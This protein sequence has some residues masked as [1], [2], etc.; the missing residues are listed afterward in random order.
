MLRSLLY[1]LLLAAVLVDISPTVAFHVSSLTGHRWP[2]TSLSFCMW[3]DNP[4]RHPSPDLPFL[5]R[6]LPFQLNSRKTRQE[7]S[8]LCQ[9]F[10][11][12]M[13]FFFF[14]N[15]NFSHLSPSGPHL[16]LRASLTGSHGRALNVTMPGWFLHRS[17]IHLGRSGR[18]DNSS[19]SSTSTN[20][21][22]H[23]QASGTRGNCTVS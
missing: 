10:V 2:T 4:K 21:A 14:W 23:G 6:S 12:G 17:G 1:P 8:Q 20:V 16:T 3:G 9:F 13:F 15:M 19:G 7:K 22:M 11:V 5:S 18:F